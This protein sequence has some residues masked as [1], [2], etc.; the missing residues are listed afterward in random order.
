MDFT[1][2]KITMFQK[3]NKNLKKKIKK[4]PH[5]HGNMVE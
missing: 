4:K 2:K 1:Q 5:G 3:Q